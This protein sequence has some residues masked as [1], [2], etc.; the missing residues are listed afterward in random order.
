ML[1]PSA[2][3]TAVAT[4][5]LL[6]G[7]RPA[8]AQLVCGDTVPAGGKVTLTADVGP[9]ASATNPALRVIGP[10]T[11]DLNGFAVLCDP[12]DPPDG[13][14]VDGKGAKILNGTVRSCSNGLEVFGEG[15]HKIENMTATGS[16]SDGFAVSSSKNKLSRNHAI[17]SADDGF[18]LFVG[19]KTALVQNVAV[20][21][22]DVG[23]LIDQSGC[24]IDRNLAAG[25]GEAGFQVSDSGNQLKGNGAVSNDDGFFVS[26]AGNKL[27]DNYAI[28]N[29]SGD[30]IDD[31]FRLTASADGNQL[32]KN[33][34]AGN[35]GRGVR[36]QNG[37][38]N[39]SVQK[40]VAQANGQSDLED[41][42]PD[43]DDN[44]WAKNVAGIRIPD[45]CI[46]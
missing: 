46:D 29:G 31:G 21:S 5:T 27:Q 26:T 17:E 28:A 10:A 40:N 6:E 9:C 36:L 3:A 11:L 45:S 22:G 24:K 12:N 1:A 20:G 39:N 42:N 34:A 32:T 23:F 2:V 8:H 44:Q 19:E 37:A 15:K 14:T 33:R 18:H 16:A 30:A 41:E 35:D 7:A 13:I 25:S 43:C 38:T 4:L